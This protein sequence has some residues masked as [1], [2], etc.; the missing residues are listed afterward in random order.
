MQEAFSE[1]I[2]YLPQSNFLVMMVQ[3]SHIEV[4]HLSDLSLYYPEGHIRM[5]A[6]HV[7]RAEIFFTFQ[8]LSRS[9]TRKSSSIS[10]IPLGEALGPAPT[11]EGI[12][13]GSLV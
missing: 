5:T 9:S 7:S 4:L 13:F 12:T 1:S 8:G 6:R 3:T 10:I 11:S 2:R